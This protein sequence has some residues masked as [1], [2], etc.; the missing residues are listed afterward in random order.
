MDELKQRAETQL[1]LIELTYSTK[2]LN[3]EEIVSVI[4]GKLKDKRQILMVCTS[5]NSWIAS[6]DIKGDTVIPIDI[7]LS[8]IDAAN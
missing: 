8:Y 7:V 3:K 4:A 1:S 5:L 6:S 2:I